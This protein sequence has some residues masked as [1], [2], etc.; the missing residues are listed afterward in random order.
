MFRTKGLKAHAH[1]WYPGEF[2]CA[3]GRP[4]SAPALVDATGKETSLI[5]VIKSDELSLLVFAPEQAGLKLQEMMTSAKAPP[6][7]SV[8]QTMNLGHASVPIAVGGTS[9]YHAKELRK[10]TLIRRAVWMNI[11]SKPAL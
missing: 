3:G 2:V 1:D 8:M 10:V 5:D 4:P 9:A 6:L 11:R 7:A